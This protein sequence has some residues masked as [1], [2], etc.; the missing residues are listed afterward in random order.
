MTSTAVVAAS[1]SPTSACTV[2]QAVL[3][4]L[5]RPEDVRMLLLDFSSVF[6]TIHSHLIMQKLMRMDT[7][8]GI[9]RWIFSLLTNRPQR[10][11]IKNGVVETSSAE[12]CTNAGA[13]QGCVLSP[14]LFILCTSDC[15][16]V[17]GCDTL[18]VKLSDDTSL[19]GV[20]T[21][22]ESDYSRTGAPFMTL[23]SVATTKR[24]QTQG[25]CRQLSGGGGGGGGANPIH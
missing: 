17:T 14:A 11:R 21:A 4:H 7:N 23:F 2:L 20:I 10:M 5:K 8:Y 1:F 9:I 16:F 24:H 13:P 19:N 25:N 18:Q 22:S 6:N 3:K 15:R 12:V